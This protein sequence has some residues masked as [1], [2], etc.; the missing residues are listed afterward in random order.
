MPKFENLETWID[1]KWGSQIALGEKIGVAG[2]T[3]S[4]WLSGKSRIKPLIQ[5]KLRKLGYDGP[6]PE[7][8]KELT[9]DDLQA[10]GRDLVRVT[11]HSHEDLKRDIQALGAAVQEILKRLE[12]SK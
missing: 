3:V 2:N 9:Q 7:G 1:V 12:G 8:N 5:D 11:N 6:F 4:Q 10:L